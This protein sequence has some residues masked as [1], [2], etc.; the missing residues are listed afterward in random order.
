MKSLAS[1]TSS[2]HAATKLISLALCGSQRIWRRARHGTRVVLTT[3]MTILWRRR[4]RSEKLAALVERIVSPAVG[5]AEWRKRA[6][7]EATPRQSQGEPPFQV[8]NN[9]AFGNIP[10]A[11]S[12]LAAFLAMI[13]GDIVGGG[14][15]R[16]CHARRWDLQNQ[17]Q[18]QSK[19]RTRSFAVYVVP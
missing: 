6:A 11:D 8:P 15:D 14:L 1:S 3:D 2:Q 9:G 7:W 18:R 17:H 16:A 12:V 4:T 10:R 13:T 19:K 5:Q